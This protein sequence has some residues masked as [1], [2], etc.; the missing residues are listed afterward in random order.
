MRAGAAVSD[1]PG[2]VLLSGATGLVGGALLRRLTDSGRVV[3]ALSR[4]PEAMPG[5]EGVVAVGWDGTTAPAGAIAGAAAAVHLAGEPIL[6]PPGAARRARIRE[7]RIASTRALVDAIGALPSEA[8]PAVLVCASA[9]GYYADDDDAVGEDA[10]PGTGFLAQLCVDWEAA[11]SGVRAH[12][13]RWV[14]LRIGVV[15]SRHG[16]ALALSS[17]PFR[18]GLGA[19][20]GSGEQWFSWIHLDDL[21]GLLVRAI[22]DP[23]FEGPYNATA[24]NPVRNA[25]F[26][27]A[28][29]AA[30][31][32]PAF[33]AVPAF[34]IRAGLGELAGEL[35]GS[36]RVLP[37]RALQAGFEFRHPEVE[38][39]LAEELGA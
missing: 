30:V 21:V 33:L 18:L 15:L 26:T 36:R 32:R 37:T 2:E 10:P 20:F 31:H 28:V 12:G 7:S 19:R 8:R 23:G 3:R 16:G 39:A 14:S 11:A 24:P 25:E 22:D 34:A 29:A 38:G 9:V 5:R 4:H 6:G 27:R 17:L 1:A 13:T 35:L